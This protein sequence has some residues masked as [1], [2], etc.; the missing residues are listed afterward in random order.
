M[1]VRAFLDDALDAVTQRAGRA[2][3]ETR[4][5]GWWHGR[6]EAP[7]NMIAPH[8]LDVDRIR[9]EFPILQQTV[10]GK[11]LVFLDSA[12]SAHE[13]GR[14]DRRHGDTMRTQYA[15]VHRGLH[16]MSERTTDAY[17]STR[18]AVAA[19]A[20]R[21]DRDEIVFTRNSTEA[22][23][24]VAHSYGRLHE[25]GPGGADL[26]DGAPRQH[27]AMADAARPHR[28][29]V[30]RG[31]RHRARRTGH[32]R[33][34]GQARR[35][36]RRPGRDDPHVQ[37]ARHLHPGRAHRRLGACGRAPRCCSTAARR[38]C[39]A[40]STCR[41]STPIS[42][43]SPA[44]SCMAPPASACCGAGMELLEAMPPFMGGG[45]MIGSVTFERTTW[46]HVPHKFEAGTPADHRGDRAEAP[47]SSGW[48]RSA[49]TPSPRTRRR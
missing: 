29:R 12:A 36:P 23:N 31:R 48:R 37:R 11:P 7:M 32:G 21:A 34:R 25:A 6:R 16:W 3:L 46:A 28:H 10:H 44:T 45:D 1:L 19:P 4:V 33:F 35:R 13:A 30:A 42:T 20:E 18:D 26:R 9:A 41:R 43:S 47:P 40:G 5:D 39:T 8:P 27:R 22:I 17:E 2:L 38:W 24:L 49:T 15:N 14:G